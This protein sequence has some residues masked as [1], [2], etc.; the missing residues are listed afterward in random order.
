MSHP[1]G[2]LLT[3][4]RARKH[5]LSQSKLAE[6]IGYD[7]AVIGKMCKGGKELTGPSGRDR[8]VRIVGA[9]RDFGA[10]TT[11]AEANALLDAAN[12]P[13]LYAG[14]RVEAA[15]IESLDGH[16]ASRSAKYPSRLPAP[17]TPL[18]GREADVATAR[19]LL[20]RDDVLLLTLLGPPGVGKTRLAIEVARQ[21]DGAFDEGVCFVKLAS[22]TDSSLL[23]PAIAMALDIVEMA[24]ASLVEQVKHTLQGRTLLLALDNVEQLLITLERPSKEGASNTALIVAELLA[25]APRVKMLLT[26]RTALR[27]SG[28]HEYYVPPLALP[29]PELPQPPNELLSYAGIKLFVE[30]AQAAAPGFALTDANATAVSSICARLDGLPLPIELAAARI[31]LFPPHTLL[32]RLD[33]R[34]TVLTGGANDLSPHQRTLRDTLNWS[35]GLLRPEEQRLLA[36]LGVFA[37]GWTL[38]AVAAVAPDAEQN[39][40][41]SADDMIESLLHHSLIQHGTDDNG[42]PRFWL[43]ETIREYALERLDA[44]GEADAVR[45]AHARFFTELAERVEAELHGPKA[46]SWLRRLTIEVD[47][48]RAALAWCLRS[49]NVDLGLRLAGAM[50]HFWFLHGPLGEGLTWLRAFLDRSPPGALQP[51]SSRAKAFSVA[52]QLTHD[53]GDFTEARHLY[54]QALVLYQGIADQRGIAATL[55]QLAQLASQQQGYD[56]KLALIGES[57]ALYREADDKWGIACCLFELGGT[58]HGQDIHAK[59]SSAIAGESSAAVP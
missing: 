36:R 13:P 39:Q 49:E 41:G 35:Y 18:I 23:V 15:L 38:E 1:F 53:H 32:A 33:Q 57:L 17:P 50:G 2:D 8:V 9:L 48:V 20:L 47:N 6:A 3:Q 28:E 7:H 14:Q 27:I 42:E 4:Y 46:A 19:R 54:N 56:T 12:L 40:N 21:L 22:I 29:N 11:L 55:M 52:G 25:C 34:L 24:G 26:S 59:P 58:R 43:L 30:R 44:S 5:G 51:A 31:K 10:L 16:S 37:G 45:Q